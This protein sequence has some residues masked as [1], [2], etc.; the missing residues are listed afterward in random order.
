MG[1]GA[2]VSVGMARV[3]PRQTLSCLAQG[4]SHPELILREFPNSVQLARP[5]S[6]R[7]RDIS[8][9]PQRRQFSQVLGVPKVV[10]PTSPD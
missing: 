7:V 9:E 2:G 5:H 6:L 4:L 8:G 3:T 1:G 10:T